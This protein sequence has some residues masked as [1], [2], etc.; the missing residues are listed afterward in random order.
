[1]R[2]DSEQG[3]LPENFETHMGRYNSAFINSRVE[4]NAIAYNQ[5]VASDEYKVFYPCVQIDMYIDNVMAETFLK[6]AEF[7]STTNLHIL[8]PTT[9][10]NALIG[11][12]LDK[13]GLRASVKQM[14]EE[15]AGKMHV[16]IDY[17]PEA[18]LNYQIASY[19]EKTA[20]VASTYMV[21]D[22]EQ[23]IVLDKGG[24]ET[25]RWV[26]ATDKVMRF[27]LRIKESRNSTAVVD[28][29]ETIVSLFLKNFTEFY[30]VGMD[31]EPE[32]YFEIN[33]DAPYAAEIIT[34]Y[35]LDSGET[36]ESDPYISPYNIKFVPELDVSNVTFE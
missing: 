35:S 3:I 10:P 11:G 13:F 25:Y 5:F 32:R 8:N 31:V 24:I 27:R 29:P 34:E 6:L 1:M 30:W 33:R 7:I 23:D 36:W 22:I 16:A 19:F 9:T 18:E 15:N 14:T 28:T 12:L 2:W 17:T 26:A 20:V 21:G 4:Y